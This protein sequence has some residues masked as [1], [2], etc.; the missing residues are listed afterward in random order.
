MT[1]LAGTW[2]LAR[3]ALRRDRVLLPVWV[4]VLAA[5]PVST[6]S[7]TAALYPTDAGRQGYIDDLGRSALLIM[8]YGPRPSPSLGALIFWRMATGMLIM[9]I[10][11][12]LVVI[13]HTRVEEEAG[14]R[15]LVRSG[16]VGRYADLAAAMLVVL[17]GGLVVALLIGL[18]MLGQHTPAAGSFAMGL[19]WAAAA[20]MSGAIAAVAAQLTRSA[21]AARGIA[22]A[23]VAVSFAVR[24]AGDVAI[25]QG[26]GP[27]WLAWTPPLGWVWSVRAYDADRWWLFAPIVLLTIA[28]VW[29]A[30]GIADRR[31]LGEGLVPSRPGPASAAPSLRA[32]LALAW[33]LHRGTLIA[34]TVGFVA[35]GLLVGA[36]AQT[37]ATLTSGNQQVEDFMERIGGHGAAA[38]ALIAAFLGI[39]GLVA[40]GYAVAAALRM[41]A[42]EAGGRLELVLTAAVPRARWTASHLVFALLGPAVVLGGVGLAAGLLYGLDVG[43]VGGQLPRVVAGALVQ[44]P[45]VWVVAGVTAAAYGVQPRLA[46]AVG[47]I[48]LAVF[49]LLGQVG[50]L[51]RFGDAALDLSPFT[52][53]PHVP[54]GSVTATPLVVLTLVAALLVGVGVAAFDRRDV[55][56]T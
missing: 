25:E 26:H 2:T 29:L 17:I 31:D 48:A 37:G 24:A 12:A 20:I 55:P 6:A 35:F 39:A 53:V 52:H 44:L 1:S 33:R 49:V 7:A 11:G 21:A 14:R 15:E 18:G 38:E 36:V 4:L 46:A 54:G 9:A 42:E 22:L 50:A 45:A 40:A 19:A 41:R 43:D 10:V 3:L 34:W 51:F 16:A 28:L 30:A 23:V 13:R 47:W 27:A 5:L 32:P 56:T 8:F